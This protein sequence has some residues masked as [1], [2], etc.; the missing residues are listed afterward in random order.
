[1]APQRQKK[2]EKKRQASPPKR[3][4]PKPTPPPPAPGPGA[5]DPARGGRK[6]SG[7][8]FPKSERDMGPPKRAEDEPG[9]GEHQRLLHPPS[10]GAVAFGAPPSPRAG[11]PRDPEPGPGDFDVALPWRGPAFSMQRRYAEPLREATPGPPDYENL[12]TL[13]HTSRCDLRE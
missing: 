11:R 8:G 4:R 2:K 3:P 12:L 6:R 13:N 1:M 7:V 5:Y 9:P 10:G